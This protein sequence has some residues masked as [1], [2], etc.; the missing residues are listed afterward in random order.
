[1]SWT[2]HL[3]VLVVE[4]NIVAAAAGA[5]AGAAAVAAPHTAGAVVL[6]G[7]DHLDIEVGHTAAGIDLVGKTS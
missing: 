3:P 7:I 4:G 2:A 5:A 6:L 1:M